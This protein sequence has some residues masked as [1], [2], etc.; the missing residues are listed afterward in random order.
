M[1]L[2]KL[3]YPKI[4]IIQFELYYN[5]FMANNKKNIKPF[6][7][8]GISIYHEQKRT[9]YSPFFS[10]KGY[11]INENNI[12]EYVSYVQSY[13]IAIVIFLATYIIYRRFWIS[14]L[15]SLAFMVSTIFIFYH[16]FLSKANVIEDYKKPARDSFVQRQADTLEE[17]NIRTIVICSP[18]LALCILIH[19]YLNHYEGS[20]FCM[21]VFIA[22]V[23]LAYGILHI[24]VL[25]RKK[26]SL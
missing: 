6:E 9:V 7:L 20:M 1:I 8:N 13:L 12:R 24:F 25:L 19:S 16:N 5:F 2:S 14:T 22:A 4:I 15:L 3:I 21:M 18:L 26:K 10:S 17:K 11:I 23:S